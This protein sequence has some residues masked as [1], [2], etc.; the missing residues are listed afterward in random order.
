MV[1]P[2]LDFKELYDH[3]KIIIKGKIYYS[4]TS[5]FTHTCARGLKNQLVLLIVVGLTIFN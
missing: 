5:A 4:E 2:I 1:F 3:V